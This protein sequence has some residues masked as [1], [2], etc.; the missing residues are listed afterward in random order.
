M[1]TI[2]TEKAISADVPKLKTLGKKPTFRVESFEY[3]KR[4]TCGFGT[5]SEAMKFGLTQGYA[6]KVIEN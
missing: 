4:V 6:F 5:R 2:N 1:R 3:E